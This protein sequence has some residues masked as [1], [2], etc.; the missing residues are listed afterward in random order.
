ML[1]AVDCGVSIVAIVDQHADQETFIGMQVMSGYDRVMVPF[2]AVVITDVVN[3]SRAFDQ[4]VRFY[5]PGRVLA[6][7]LL[8]LN[9]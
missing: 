7:S 8:G 9:V 2:D 5:G 4:A 1:S 6:P 3:S